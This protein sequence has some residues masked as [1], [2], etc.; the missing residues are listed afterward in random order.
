MSVKRLAKML[1]GCKGIA[2]DSVSL[3]E[4]NGG[5]S[6]V[7]SVYLTKDFALRD[8]DG[9]EMLNAFARVGK[10]ILIIGELPSLFS[11]IA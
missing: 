9:E 8:P 5:Q 2:I 1:L 6:V 3:R 10:P 4:V 7:V 11:R